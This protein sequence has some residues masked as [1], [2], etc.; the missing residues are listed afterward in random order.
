MF[1][2]REFGGP[3]PEGWWDHRAIGERA[4]LKAARRYRVDAHFRGASVDLFVDAVPV[5]SVAVS[6]PQGWPRNV[7]IFCRGD[8]R[9]TIRNFKVEST[10]PKAFVVMQFGGQYDEVYQDVV[11]EVCKT[12][13]V[14]TL[15]ADEVSGPGLI[16]GDIVR[17]IHGAQLIIADITPVNANVY[18]EVGYALA[19]GKPT[20]LLAQRGTPLP[21]DVAGFRV[22]FYEDTIG[23]K[24]RLEA[25]LKKHLDAILLR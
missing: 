1:G 18:F 5:G 22:L 13:E 6:S 4:N 16:V 17:E 10:K 15:R 11:K 19:L 12:Y 3:K 20:L 21:F 14:N 8:H 7:G 23:G 9:L 24:K 2:I 25:G